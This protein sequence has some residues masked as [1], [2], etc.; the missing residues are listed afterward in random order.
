MQVMVNGLPGKMA[1]AVAELIVR[2]GGPDFQLACIA[3]T[4]PDVPDNYYPYSPR[5]GVDL[6]HPGKLDDS[7]PRIGIFL[8][9]GD[10]FSVDFTQP[11]ASTCNAELYCRLGIPFVMGTTGGDRE[12]IDG[13]VK[14]SDISAVIAPNMAQPIVAFQAMMEFAAKTF[15]GA[16]HG[17]VMSVTESHQKGKA[18]TSGTA[19]AVIAS[20]KEF[21][22]NF[23]PKQLHMVREPEEQL[24]MGVPPEHLKGH[25]WHTYGLTTLDGTVALK[26][27]HNVNGRMPYAAGTLNALAFLQ[28]KMAEGSKGKVFSMIDVLRG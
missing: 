13:L 22:V 11:A 23:D 26:F 1:T 10:I 4:G 5:E 15:P 24:V 16:F 12:R 6:I 18:D 7:L 2:Q 25:G 20:L 28:K 19:K 9:R 17:F 3:L 14:Q 8:E 27:V 21:G